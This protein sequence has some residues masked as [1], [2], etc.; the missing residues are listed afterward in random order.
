MCS[1]KECGTA[2]ISGRRGEAAKVHGLSGVLELNGLRR[3]YGDVVALDG[4]SFTVSP[5][6]VFG[7]LG[8]NGAGKTTAMRAIVG[9]ASVDAGEVRWNGETIGVQARSR[10]GYM[11]EER[12]LYPAMKV[13]EQL[14]YLARLHGLAAAKARANALAWSERLGLAGQGQ[15]KVEALS[16]GNQQRVQLAA[17]LVHEPSLLV[18]DEPFSGLDPAGVDAMSE[19]LAERAA[20]GVTMLFSSH[21]LDLVEHLC[22]SVAIIHRGRLVAHGSVEELGNGGRL[23]IAVRVAGDDTAR[24]ARQLAGLAEV[25]T[26]TAGT[27]VLALSDR[28]DAQVVL[29]R[30]R[31]AGPVEQFGFERRKLSEVFRDA[32]GSGVQDETP[33]DSSG[34]GE[35]S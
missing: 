4:L 16:L 33:G 19:V 30:A 20:A 13:L 12:G 15:A 1:A 22:Q 10:I 18:L 3:R 32:V 11:P 8:P 25:E 27:V 26:V 9:V 28:A 29:D 21:Q 23:R 24:W 6:R 34:T 2:L 17:A 7:F 5:G 14:E 35:P 31:A